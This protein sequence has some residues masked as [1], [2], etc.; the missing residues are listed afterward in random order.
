MLVLGFLDIGVLSVVGLMI[1]F[2]VF[3][4]CVEFNNLVMEVI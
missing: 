2:I 3:F 4:C 1:V